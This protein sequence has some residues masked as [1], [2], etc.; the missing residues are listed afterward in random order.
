MR[1]LGPATTT[2]RF[3]LEGRLGKRRGLPERRDAPESAPPTAQPRRCERGAGAERA[4]R[5]FQRPAPPATPGSP[6]TRHG[7]ERAATSAHG[8]A[9]TA[10]YVAPGKSG[11]R[12]GREAARP[13]RATRPAWRSALRCPDVPDAPPHRPITATPSPTASTAKSFAA[14][15]LRTG[16]VAGTVH[17]RHQGA[18]GLPLK[19]GGRCESI[20]EVVSACGGG[21]GLAHLRF[22]PGRRPRFL[23]MGREPWPWLGLLRLD[24]RL[25]LGLRE[26]RARVVARRRPLVGPRSA[27]RPRPAALGTDRRRLAGGSRIRRLLGTRPALRPR[28]PLRPRLVARSRLR[29]WPHGLA[30][31]APAAVRAGCVGCVALRGVCVPSVVLPCARLLLERSRAP[32]LVRP[33]IRRLL[34]LRPRRR[35]QRVSRASP[36]ETGRPRLARP[37]RSAL[38]AVRAPLQGR[39]SR[40]RDGQRPR[41]ADVASRPPVPRRRLGR[42]GRAAP[43]RPPARSR[44]QGQA[45]KPT[46]LRRSRAPAGDHRRIRPPR[47][48]RRP[49]RR[50]T[51]AYGQ[52]SPDRERS[53]PAKT[54][55]AAPRRPRDAAEEGR[56]QAAASTKKRSAR[57]QARAPAARPDGQARTRAPTPSEE[58]AGEAQEANEARQVARPAPQ[59]PRVPRAR[60]RPRRSARVPVRAPRR[61]QGANPKFMRTPRV[62]REEGR[63]RRRAD[64]N[65]RMEVLQ[66]SALPLG[67]GADTRARSSLRPAE[68]PNDNGESGKPD[69]NR[70]PPP[71]Q[72][73]ALPTELFPRL[74]PATP[75]RPTT[76]TIGLGG[77]GCQPLAAARF[78][79]GSWR[80]RASGRLARAV[81]AV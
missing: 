7:R 17:A 47:K 49:P 73:G 3:A 59:C 4:P 27:L 68:P 9:G 30:R 35:R 74:R 55:P 63:K 36:F 21:R 24:A 22:R 64:S 67:Y 76:R 11:R 2:G 37:S 61:A 42:A 78:G 23:G 18:G 58:E 12:A 16:R 34:A 8:A 38:A 43:N 6:R 14:K 13:A 70:R 31:L 46:G 60:T 51:A 48:T 72:G 50:A 44:P 81:R 40:L 33:A 56:G 29:A 10:M 19:Q 53:P 77:A 57:G 62:L 69:S 80:P 39:P 71:W 5:P 79:A 52:D 75:R 66:T 25:E 26:P 20:P 28:L 41:A 54:R 65:R 32:G 45:A 15:R 1:K